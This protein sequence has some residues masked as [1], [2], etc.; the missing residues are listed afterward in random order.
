M[1]F[2][3]D[4][5]I[6]NFYRYL[7][8]ELGIHVYSLQFQRTSPRQCFLHLETIEVNKRSQ[9]PLN[10]HKNQLCFINTNCQSESKSIYKPS[11]S[12]SVSTSSSL[13]SHTFGLMLSHFLMTIDGQKDCSKIIKKEKNT[14]FSSMHTYISAQFCSDGE[15]PSSTW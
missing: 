6:V 10:Q 7:N 14:K 4:I 8:L 13:N 2:T 5:F 9:Y 3:S 12:L 11:S 1:D 15:L